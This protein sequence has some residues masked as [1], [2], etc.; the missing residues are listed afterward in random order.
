MKNSRNIL[1]Q[2]GEIE[3]LLDE[4]QTSNPKGIAIIAHPHPLL[5]GSANHKIPSF[6]AKELVTQGW[7]TA[8]MNFRGAGNSA[9]THDH[10]DGETDDLVLLTQHLLSEFANLNLTLIG[11]SFGA[12]VQAKAAKRLTEMGHPIHKLCLLAMPFGKVQTGRIYAPPQDIP[13]ALVVHGEL[14]EQIP[15][16]SIFEWARST[17]KPVCVMTGSDHLFSGQLIQLKEQ[18]FNYLNTNT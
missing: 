1:G 6:I 12:Y 2:E 14:D 13:N 8:R 5:G 18:L 4:P 11:I 3:Y 10:G 9:G 17:K 7:T 15:I 16:S